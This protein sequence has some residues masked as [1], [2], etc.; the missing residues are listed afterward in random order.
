MLVFG[1]LRPASFLMDCSCIA[2]LTPVVIVIRG[3]V[4]QHLFRM[5][6]ISASYFVCFCV[7]ACSGNLS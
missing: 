5:A 7:R 3:F 2:H 1:I 4:F 6:L